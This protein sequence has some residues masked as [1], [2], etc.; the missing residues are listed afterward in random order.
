LLN[1]TTYAYSPTAGTLTSVTDAEGGQIKYEYDIYGRVTKLTDQRNHS[2]NYVY[3]EQGRLISETNPLNQTTNYTYHDEPTCTS[4]GNMGNHGHLAS[5]TDPG[6]RSKT[7]QYDLAGRLTDIYFMAPDG[8][9]IENVVTH[10]YDSYG[11]KI[12]TEDSRLP[13]ADYPTQ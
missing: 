9:T 7:Y 5:T 2:T 6:G 11:R 13:L 12:A 4:C 3:D 10:T 8:T 1:V